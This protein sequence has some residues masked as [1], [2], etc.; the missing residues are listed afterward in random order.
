ML[1]SSDFVSIGPL[2]GFL[3]FPFLLPSSPL[4]PPGV[5]LSLLNHLHMNPHLRILASRT[6]RLKF[7]VILSHSMCN[8]LSQKQQETKTL[9][10]DKC[11]VGASLGLPY[12]FGAEE[13][14]CQCRRRGF[15]PWVGK[16]LWRRKWQPTPVFL[17]RESHGQR[18]LVGYSPWDC[19][20]GPD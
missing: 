15:N 13:S 9:A 12:W 3:L 11:L 4:V 16:I 7:S 8:N 14:A 10:Q 20:V 19:T 6:E 2:F 17:T 18:S 1:P 5:S